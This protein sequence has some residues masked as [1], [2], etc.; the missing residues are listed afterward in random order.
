ML[1]EI[2]ERKSV[3]NFSDNKISDNDLKKILQAI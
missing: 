2:L 1:N 3:R